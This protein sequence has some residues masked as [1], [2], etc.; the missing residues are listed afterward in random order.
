M[1]GFVS[2]NGFAGRTLFD[3]TVWHPKMQAGGT[4]A[5]FGRGILLF[6]TVIADAATV[7]AALAIAIADTATTIAGLAN[8]IAD[9]ANALADTASAIAKAAIMLA[10]PAIVKPEAESAI[11][12]L[13]SHALHPG[14]CLLKADFIQLHGS[15]W[16]RG[17]VRWR[18]ASLPRV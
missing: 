18:W 9:P 3:A 14:L 10:R 12:R 17:S 11:P 5:G 4:I 13:N 7:L 1:R 2:A 15:D 8:A 6:G 16:L